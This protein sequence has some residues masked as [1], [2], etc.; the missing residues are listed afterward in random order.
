MLTLIWAFFECLLGIANPI[1]RFGTRV[2]GQVLK[3]D[4]VNL[5]FGR[6][7]GT[8]FHQDE[9]TAHKVFLFIASCRVFFVRGSSDNEWNSC[10]SG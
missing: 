10:I 1:F 3:V 9:C 7:G 2:F 5:G 4:S 6:E 8:P